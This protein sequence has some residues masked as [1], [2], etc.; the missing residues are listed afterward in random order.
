MTATIKYEID[1]ECVRVPYGPL[2]DEIRN[3]GGF[4]DLRGRPELACEVAEAQRSSALL[5][6]LVVLAQPSSNVFSL[7]CDLGS[8]R[9]KNVPKRMRDVAGGYVWVAFKDYNKKRPEDYRKLAEQIAEMMQESSAGHRW[10]L[11]FIL[12][13][14]D[15]CL[16]NYWTLYQPFG[17]GSMLARRMQQRRQHQERR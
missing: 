10:E 9:E 1:Q 2:V 5:R 12:K 7:G 17:Y 16:D 13:G 8:H 15:F 11:T 14:A 4:T 3:N 6:L